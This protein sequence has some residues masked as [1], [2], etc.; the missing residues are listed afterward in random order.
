MFT[1]QRTIHT[2]RGDN[3]KCIFVRI[4][5]FFDLRLFILY[6]APQSRALAPACS[7]ALVFYLDVSF[8]T[9]GNLRV[10]I[11]KYMIELL[12]NVK[13]VHN[14]G[15]IIDMIYTPQKRDLMYQ[16]KISIQASLRSPRR[17][18]LGRNPL[19]LVNFLKLKKM[20][21]IIII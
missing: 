10:L 16:Q 21:I 8:T 7:C 17:L 4:I 1:I 18:A 6:Q 14:M 19:L 20:I 12:S 11:V 13:W 9:K 5:P 2:I 15:T 3:S